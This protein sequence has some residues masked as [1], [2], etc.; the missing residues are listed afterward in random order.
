M[1]NTIT[2]CIGPNR[3]I[4]ALT[5]SRGIT[6]EKILPPM[7]KKVD[8]LLHND[9]GRGYVRS[10]PIYLDAKTEE[11]LRDVTDRTKRVLRAYT[12]NPIPNMAAMLLWDRMGQ[13]ITP[14][15]VRIALEYLGLEE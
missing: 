13:H 4:R 5:N 15:S 14:E 1:V 8:D 3:A 7:I 6:M 2:F 12:N 9:K 10:D 11:Y